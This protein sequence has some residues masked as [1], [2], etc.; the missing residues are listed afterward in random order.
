MLT[1]PQYLIESSFCL[2]IFYGFYH[3]FLKKETFFQLNRGFLIAAPILSLCIPLLNISFQKDA[4]AESLEA[5]FYPAIES[6]HNINELV[7]EQMR[8]PSPVFSLSVAD[9]IMA[10]YLVGVAFMVFTLSRSLWNLSKIIRGGK[11]S[12]NNEFTLVETVLEHEKVHIRQWHSLDVL[13]MEICVIIKW[14]NPLIYWFR[15]ALKVTH[16]YI[17]DQYVIDQKSNVGDYAT[18]LVNQHKQLTA[19]PLTNTFYSLTKKRL[20]M[21]LQSPSKRIDGLKYLTV[22]PIII[23]LMLLF[24]FNLLEEIPQVGEQLDEMNAALEDIGATTVFEINQEQ[25]DK[26]HEELMEFLNDEQLANFMSTESP[27][28]VHF[29]DEKSY[30]L[31]SFN[32]FYGGA[33]NNWLTKKEFLNLLEKEIHF[34]INSNALVINEIELAVPKLNGGEPYRLKINRENNFQF[35]I[36]QL[37]T[38][39]DRLTDD[40]IIYFNGY[41][42]SDIYTT[43]FHIKPEKVKKK[44]KTYELFWGDEE[45][46][47]K[48]YDGKDNG[49]LGY[50]MTLASFLNK[51]R[52]PLKFKKHNQAFVPKDI[53]ISI[54]GKYSHVMWAINPDKKGDLDYFE[55]IVFESKKPLEEGQT[56]EYKE[57]TEKTL[58]YKL[59]GKKE[60]YFSE[61][62]VAEILDL[63]DGKITVTIRARDKFLLATSIT[64]K[65]PSEA[66]RPPHKIKNDK[67]EV[68]NFQLITPLKGKTILK[69]DTIKSAKI[70]SYYKDADKYKIIHIPNFQTVERVLDEKENAEGNT[71]PIIYNSVTQTDLLPNYIVGNPEKL[72]LQWGDLLAEPESENLTLKNFHANASAAPKLFYQKEQLD[73]AKIRISAIGNKTVYTRSFDK[74]DFGTN[75]METFFKRIDTQTSIY[76]DKIE[77]LDNGV[78]KHLQHRFLFKIGNKVLNKTSKSKTAKSSVPTTFFETKQAEKKDSNDIESMYFYPFSYSNQI[79][80]AKKRLRKPD[81][82]YVQTYAHSMDNYES[83]GTKQIKNEE[84]LAAFGEAGRKGIF[85]SH[86]QHKK[87]RKRVKVDV[88]TS[89]LIIY[90][91]HPYFPMLTHKLIYKDLDASFIEKTTTYPAGS[92]E[93]N[94]YG[95][96]GKNGV[97]KIWFK[98]S[99][100]NI[101][102][103][104]V[105]V[106]VKKANPI[107]SKI[108][109]EDNDYYQLMQNIPLSQAFKNLLQLPDNQLDFNKLKDNFP[110]RI[111]VHGTLE[112]EHDA[113]WMLEQIKKKFPFTMEEKME[114]RKVLVLKKGECNSLAAFEYFQ[115]ILPKIKS[116]LSEN[117]NSKLKTIAPGY[118]ADYQKV[119]KE[120]FELPFIDE[121][122]FFGESAICL[123]LDISSVENMKKQL[124][125]IYGLELVEEE[126]LIPVFEF[127]N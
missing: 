16:E 96:A 44:E 78:T 109:W 35:S 22:F 45:I 15:N 63:I 46:P 21:M 111:S 88:K 81:G 3:F 101:G 99:T 118:I 127:S 7:W 80:L 84:G 34:T 120:N 95:E 55:D 76:L 70:A 31:S 13:L 91:T 9:V 66:Y 14:F 90:Y 86:Y 74:A 98:R 61:K 56:I 47:L 49:T 112:T 108:E 57:P 125:A 69:I 4:P 5:L 38:L 75:K 105:K 39:K 97:K 19:T 104:P 113:F 48:H 43:E 27:N 122:G 87:K 89:P 20:Q 62:E 10:T 1:I 11:H 68:F 124:K 28:K 106:T 116:V 37:V 100:R 110:I 102:K 73:Y 59:K 41:N 72:R 29:G 65:E 40:D 67:K 64:A 94:Y 82:T 42:G 121:T 83:D 8:A 32:P 2:L 77:I 58:K 79:V 60:N 6:A 18:L 93:A 52:Q 25:D 114:K 117:Q 51:L 126:R 33:H 123:G 115:Q 53:S 17:A 119:I 92:K 107:W 30:F 26:K 50:E 12:K 24:S 85:V 36:T 71:K 23:G 54:Y 103:D